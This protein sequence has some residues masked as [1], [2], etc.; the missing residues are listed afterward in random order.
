MG[1]DRVELSEEPPHIYYSTIL[2]TAVRNKA[3]AFWLTPKSNWD[4]ELFR[5]GSYRLNELA[6]VLG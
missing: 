2:Q 6:I 3:L 1:S 4:N 5:L